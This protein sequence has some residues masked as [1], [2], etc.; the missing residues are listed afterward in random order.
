MKKVIYLDNNATTR[1]AP[2][3]LEEMTPYFS[4][5]YGNP[6]SM[7]SFGGG[8]K[9]KIEEA[10]AK[11]A[12]LINA[13]ASEIIFT[14][15]GTEADNTALFSA[16][17]TARPE[18]KRIITS[19][20]EHPAIM[21]TVRELASRGY[22]ATF[23]GVEKDG[24][25]NMTQ[26]ETALSSQDAAMVSMMWANSETGV[27]FPIKEITALAH[28]YGALMHTDA[29][30]ALGKIPVDVK[31]AG[32]DMMSISAHK[33]HG[34]KGIGALYLKQGTPF[35]P[36]L[37]GGH[38]ER[39]LRA[40]TENVPS[41]TG[42]GKA[43]EMAAG[44]LKHAPRIAALRD[45]LEREITAAIPQTKINGYGANRLP[46]TT[47]ISFGYI[48][49]EAI[50]LH[51]DDLGICASSGSACTSGSLEPSHVMRAMCVDFNFAHSST[52][53]SL[54]HYTTEE[55]IDFVIKSVPPVIEKLRAISPFWQK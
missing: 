26:L 23:I 25:L 52:R 15:S 48:E 2:E 35:R 10:R 55:E 3:V 27:I 46:N 1:T 8:N 45:R 14:G 6:S 19:A 17:Q 21:E 11:T 20:V 4:D 47:N 49:G 40:G 12:A 54:S 9:A 32:V 51:L 18:R 36:Y 33:I 24:S 50:L 44:N 53:F 28:K 22:A 41:I 42:F 13:D 30:Q 7:H 31:D 43:C 37:I 16:V 39:G 34:P 29:V 5:K 38:Q